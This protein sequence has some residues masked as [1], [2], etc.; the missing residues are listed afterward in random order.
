MQA[1]V[2]AGA[3]IY[4]SGLNAA[5]RRQAL[6][7]EYKGFAQNL[8]CLLLSVPTVNTGAFTAFFL[9]FHPSS[10][11]RE[12]DAKDIHMLDLRWLGQQIPCICHQCGSDRAGQMG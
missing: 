6:M 11:A 3:T 12:F 7:K 5:R 4:K 2:G 8:P 9:F 1:G 10:S